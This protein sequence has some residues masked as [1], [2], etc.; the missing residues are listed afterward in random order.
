[1]VQTS[2]EPRRR[3][4]ADDWIAAIEWR[5]DRG[6]PFHAYDLWKEASERYPDD[7]D[8]C[9][10]G[11]LALIKGRSIR[12]ARA[13]LAGIPF[14]EALASES[15]RIRAAEVSRLLWEIEGVP[16][17]LALAHR[18][19]S[20]LYADGGEAVHGVQAALLAH[21]GGN[22]DEA[23]SIARR[24]RAEVDHGDPALA[25][26]R[27]MIRGHAALLLDDGAEAVEHYTAGAG[28]RSDYHAVVDALR[29]VRALAKSGA[30]VP[31]EVERILRPPTVV[32]FGG[33]TI[34]P[35]GLLV[36][37]FPPSKEA[38]VARAIRRALDEMDARIGYSSAA[39]G[40]DL[41]FAEALLARG[42]EVHIVLPCALEDFVEARV[43]YAGDDWVER[44]HRVLAASEVRHATTER[45]LGHDALLRFG[46]DMITGLGWVRS[47]ALLTEPRLLA[48]LD[49]RAPPTAGSPADF[50]DHW[51]DVAT[52]HLV[53]ID[54]LEEGLGPPA[55]PRAPVV[56]HLEP[57]RQINAML[58][59][60]VVGYSKLGE[61]H[62]PG[63]F[64]ML[65][66]LH[67]RFVA[68]GVAPAL[69]EAWGDALY[70]V[71]PSARD[72]L[73][74]AFVLQQAF[75]DLDPAAFALPVRLAV[76]IG[77]HAGPVFPMV[78]PVSGRPV[79]VGSQVNRAA[80][81]EPITIPGEV[82]ASTEYVALLT[83]EENARRHELRY[84][85][86]A[87]APWYRWD[88]LGLID[89][90]KRFGEQAIYHLVPLGPVVPDAADD[91]LADL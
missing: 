73:R 12:T 81:I 23:S 24:L 1:M 55:A 25:R 27:A 42:G 51:A 46:N 20:R 75:L 74:C 17:D 14:E 15:A 30:R 54:Q 18:G 28:D 41:L 57:E 39:C 84:R 33:Q 66:R 72:L 19:Y 78:H 3:Q 34:D 9:L 87:Y 63:F 35:P 67:E 90:P 37:L 52:L 16:A 36:P 43:A 68:A 38:P 80:R 50:I 4:S 49:Y 21:L 79:Y 56:D 26:R 77:L 62:L 22:D 6:R 88:Y 64:R 58:F 76:R 32:I 86:K 29:V 40:C 59:A 48:A 11:V 7:Q 8:L 60:D 71:I 53:L 45:Y 85:R 91:S 5:L 70:I 44:F 61:Q 65:A 10:V 31:P 47:E 89:L 83:A 69:V 82:Y 13:A 2:E